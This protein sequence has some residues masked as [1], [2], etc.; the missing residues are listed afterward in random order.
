MSCQD[1]KFFKIE[2][3]S[4][5]SPYDFLVCEMPKQI[6]KMKRLS[7]SSCKAKFVRVKYY[8]KK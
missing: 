5:F 2:L 3:H 8:F 6:E 7:C 1:C 4:E